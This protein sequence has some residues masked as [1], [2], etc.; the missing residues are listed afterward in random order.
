MNP[1]IEKP[2]VVTVDA[3]E[4][5]SA[6]VLAAPVSASVA[7]LVPYSGLNARQER[8]AQGVAGGLSYFAA[9]MEAGYT[10]NEGSARRDASRLASKREVQDRI[11]E[12][13]AVAGARALLSTTELI[14]DLEQMATADVNEIMALTNGACRWCWGDP[15]GSYSW[16]SEAEMARAVD[17]YMRSLTTPKP[18]PAP[19]TSGGFNYDSTRSPNDHC[20]R[21]EGTGVTRVRFANTESVSPGARKLYR[22][23][24]LYGDG[25]VKRVLLGD[26]LAARMELHKVR[27]LHVERSVA[28]NV[29]ASLPKLENMTQEQMLDFLESLKPTKG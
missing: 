29:N 5:P 21:C 16:R 6:V 17:A 27:G 15:P 20:E 13:Q 12:L 8:F 25:T 14:A 22:G 19:D 11:R 1:T 10:N 24:E 4:A 9:Y 7:T 23:V 2:L 28:V 26:P 18:L 3:P